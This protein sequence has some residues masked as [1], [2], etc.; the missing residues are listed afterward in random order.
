MPR[1][2]PSHSLA[3]IEAATRNLDEVRQQF[4]KVEAGGVELEVALTPEAGKYKVS[5][6]A[7]RV[8]KL[9]MDQIEK[10]DNS[11]Y[12]IA[13]GEVENLVKAAEKAAN[14]QMAAFDQPPGGRGKAPASGGPQAPIHVAINNNQGVAPAAPSTNVQDVV[15]VDLSKMQVVK[16]AETNG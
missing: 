6:L 11:G 15:T 7:A 5:L 12:P 8:N 1:Q 14:L 9:V 13:P 16:E 4:A 3:I 10:I 2:K